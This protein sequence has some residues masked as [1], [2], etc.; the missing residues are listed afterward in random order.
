MTRVPLIPA[1]NLGKYEQD[2][3]LFF[4]AF[5]EQYL[6]IFKRLDALIAEEDINDWLVNTPKT[7]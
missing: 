5:E 3:N 6:R 7:F 1:S 2:P 4:K